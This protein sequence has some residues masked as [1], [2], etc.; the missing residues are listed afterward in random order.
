MW[1]SAHRL[2]LMGSTDEVGW[3]PW[4]APLLRPGNSWRF[5]PIPSRN[6]MPTATKTSAKASKGASTKPAAGSKP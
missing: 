1:R 2:Q 6:Y 3:G 5:L 4:D